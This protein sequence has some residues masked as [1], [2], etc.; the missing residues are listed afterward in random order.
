M[1]ESTG[2]QTMV[3]FCNQLKLIVLKSIAE[4]FD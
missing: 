1:S 3:Q 4:N 2:P